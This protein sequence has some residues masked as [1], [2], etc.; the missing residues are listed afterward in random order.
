[1]RPAMTRRT[2]LGLPFYTL[3]AGWHNHQHRYGAGVRAGFR[4]WEVD[5]MYGVLKALSWLGLVWDLRPVLKRVLA[6]LGAPIA[7][8]VG[9][10]PWGPG[11]RRTGRAPSS[12]P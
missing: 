11:A 6:E 12:D 5:P 3:G 9:P 10:D 8:P 7:S 1:M 4:W 2:A